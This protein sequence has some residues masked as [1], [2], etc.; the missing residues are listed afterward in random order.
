MAD[1]LMDRFR[2][3]DMVD[4]KRVAWV[5]QPRQAEFMR[6]F[7]DEVL[8]G[9][10]AGGGKSDALIAEALRQISVPWYKGLI[11]R[12]TYPQLTEL[13]DKAYR[14]YPQID[15]KAKYNDSKHTW[16]FRSG[17]KIAFGSLLHPKNKFDYQGR[18]YDFI[19]FDELTHFTAEEYEY[20]RSRNRPSGPGTRCYMR[21]T[22]NPGGIG[23]TWVKARFI[24]P[25]P[26]MTTIWEDVEIQEDSGAKTVKRMSRIFIPS[27]VEDNYALMSNDPMYKVKLLSLP[28][29]ERKALYNGDWNSYVGQVFGEF[30]NDPDHY[31]DGKYTNVIQPFEPP[32]FWRVLRSFDWGYN[33][34]FSVGWFAVDQDG[35]MYRILEWYGCKPVRQDEGLQLDASE[36]FE[37]IARMEREHPYLK[38]RTIRGVADP[39]IWQKNG[40]VSINE[41]AQRKG[42]YFDKADNTRIAGIAQVHERL[43]FGKD[44]RPRLYVF[45]TCRDFIRVFPAQQYDPNKP[46]DV[47]TKGE[48]HIFDECRYA[49]MQNPISSRMQERDDNWRE[50][51]LNLYLDVKRGDLKR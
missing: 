3:G 51:P 24:D 11:L 43:R 30:T 1:Q 10:A 45:N 41:E 35:I 49:C 5:P 4:G 14:L 39:A 29:A 23:H 38:G 20:L 26:A 19:A 27:K 2:P 18:D 40:G 28:E 25:A 48:D 6:R 34:P 22:A 50:N 9:G 42:V 15:P 17:A 36:V 46:E 7:E 47:D 16:T 32:K 44:G 37:Q 31:K 33:K 8:F 21:A 13:I 12:K